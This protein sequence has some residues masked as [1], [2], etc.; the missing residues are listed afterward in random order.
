[1]LSRINSVAHVGLLSVPVEVEVDVAATGFPAFTIVGLPNKAV[2][3]AKERVR[4]A[5]VNSGF[6]FPTKKI[7]VNLAPADLAK[8][9]SCYDLPIAIGILVASGQLPECVD[10]K[11]SIFYGELSLDGT[12]R[13]TKGVLLVGIFAQKK[14]FSHVFV[15][16]D[17]APQAAVVKGISVFGVRN[18][19]TLVSHLLG[20]EKVLS[21]IVDEKSHTPDQIF[22]VDFADV[23]G[24]EQAKRALCIAASGGHNILM[25]GPPGS[26]KTLLA[27]ALPSILPP[28]TNEESLEVTRIYSATGLLAPGEALVRKRPF[29]FPHHSTSLAGLIGGGSRPIPGEISLAH[30]GVMFLDEMAEFPRSL[31]EALRQP[32]EDGKVVVSRAA[33]RIEYPA[34]FML[35]AAVNPCPCGFLGHPKKECTCSTRQIENYKKRLSGP[36]LDR[37]DLQIVVPTVEANQIG[38]T[39][40][41]QT[42]S[43]HM[44]SQ[45]IRA[46][47]IQQHRFVEQAHV[48]TN[49]QMKQKQLHIFC[50]L[51][52]EAKRLLTLAVDKHNLSTRGYVRIIKVARTIADLAGE[53][54]ILPTHVAEALQY[55][56]RVL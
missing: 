47:T 49:A 40:R 36:I 30:L 44:L 25:S 19:R 29:R 12:L 8:E 39:Q 37:I 18:L 10:L 16:L 14:K 4:T 21:F 34:S 53:K 15:P 24:Q 41:S 3:E 48:Y 46:R 55:R 11:K 2:E 5:I 56:I 22:E 52:A 27:K 45:V 1:M 28:L 33:G 17:S 35:V 31:L 26:G 50:E 13:H 32:M 6:S 23:Y 42:S 54:D 51:D 43:S 9:G 38:T 7:T 20:Q